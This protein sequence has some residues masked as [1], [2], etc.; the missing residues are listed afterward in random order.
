MDAEHFPEGL[1]IVIP[2]FD[3]EENLLPLLEEIEEAMAPLPTAY[4]IIA[5]DDGSTDSSL[6][7]LRSTAA[8]NPRL[9]VLSNPRRS[10]QSAALAAGLRAAREPVVV[11][12]DSDL[13]NDPRDI[14]KLLEAL[15]GCDVV[16]GIRKER[17][18]T[19]VRRLS[20][21]IA[22]DVRRRVLD[23]GIHDVGCSLKA[24]RRE[25]VE[26]LPPFEGMHRFLPALTR[27]RGA[28]IREIEVNHRPRRHGESKYRIGNRLWRGIVDLCGVSWLR[29]RWIDLGRFR[30]L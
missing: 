18:D 20:S 7:I 9:R 6:E 16:S 14:P 13:Q 19:W 15:A 24:F 22:N 28:R 2:V 5:V 8:S 11:T 26:A 3:E 25:F 10:G 30:E 12:M 23:D 4:E 17:K 29:R 1:S 21:R 27:F